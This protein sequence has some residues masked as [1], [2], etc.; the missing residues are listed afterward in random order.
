LTKCW[1]LLK[2]NG[3]LLYATCSILPE[4]NYQQ[5]QRFVDDNIDAE[6]I[7]INNDSTQIGWQIVPNEQSMDG[8]YYAKLTK[9]A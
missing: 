6:L 8:F 7:T 5:V 3:T 4:E 9:K 1:S 2:P